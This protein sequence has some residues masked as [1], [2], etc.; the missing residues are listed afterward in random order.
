MKYK[1]GEEFLNKLYSNMHMSDVVM[2]T[3]EKSNTPEEKIEKYMQRLEKIHN[4]AKTKEH[5]MNILKEFYYN[6][7]IIKEVPDNYIKLQQKIARE[8]GYG[9]IDITASKKQ[10]MLKTIQNDQKKSLDRWI[11]YLTSDDADY[12]M[13]FKN[14]AFT[15]MLKL[16][17]FDKEKGKF[18]K[19][20]STTTEPYLDLNREILAYIYSTLSHEIGE[21]KL[22]DED[23]EAISHGESFQ[24][25][26]LYYT[27]KMGTY[28]YSSETEGKWVK[29]NQGKNYKELW[30]SLQGK[31]TGWC[32]AGEETCKIQLKSGDFYVYYTK[33][34][35]GN[36]T[37]P[38]IAIRMNG[39]NKIA[40]VRGVWKNQ[41]LEKNMIEIAENK[42]DE[43]PNKDPYKKKVHDM[44]LLTEIETKAKENTDLTKEELKFLYE[45][46][47][48]IQGF[49][50]ENDP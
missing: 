24:K 37:E 11:D 3:A 46:D 9:N 22:I 43:F 28:E 5:K 4:I 14:Y 41:N 47:S 17:K 29:Y 36:Y 30:L 32:T 31:N 21:S 27:K 20:T 7:Y 45:I 23:I 12:P 16:G 34:K 35:E 6:K 1:N 42:L 13:W 26:Y 19:R 49:S 10:E 33:D 2:H 40:E 25:M 50:H 38:R 18:Q 8:Q 15:G 39:P 48:K 44:K